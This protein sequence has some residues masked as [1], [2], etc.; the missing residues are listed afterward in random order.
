MFVWFLANLWG[1]KKMVQL[2]NEKEEEEEEE[3]KDLLKHSQTK[4]HSLAFICSFSNS[5]IY[6]TKWR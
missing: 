5:N 2:K 6:E 3:R 1:L 4:W